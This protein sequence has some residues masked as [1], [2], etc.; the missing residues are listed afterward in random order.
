MEKSPA[1]QLP[2]TRQ[3]SLRVRP[4]QNRRVPLWAWIGVVGLAFAA[5]LPILQSSAA[6]ESGAQQLSLENERSALQAEVRLLA[7]KV[8]ELA[9]L[10]R[11]GNVASGR[12]G[13]TQAQPTT[14]L[15]VDTPPP[16]QLVPTR[17]LPSRD[18]PVDQ[19]IPTWARWLEIL[20][21]R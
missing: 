1:L 13:L 6:T 3:A 7:S 5:L 14:V 9:A 16:V 19:V 15:S 4:T 17:Y 11:I 2:I 10:N 20:I 18:V 12:L 21:V 8:G